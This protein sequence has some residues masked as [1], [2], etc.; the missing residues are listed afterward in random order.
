MNNNHNN[1]YYLEERKHMVESDTERI[2][3]YSL[4]HKCEPLLW[5]VSDDAPDHVF[6]YPPVRHL[7][8]HIL[9]D[10]PVSMTT[11]THLHTAQE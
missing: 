3:Y 1:N 11:I 10:V 4:L 7:G 6:W 9:Q 2:N 5:V 8:D